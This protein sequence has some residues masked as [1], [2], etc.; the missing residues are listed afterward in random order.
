VQQA[1]GAV[2]ALREKQ[3]DHAFTPKRRSREADA[4]LARHSTEARRTLESLMQQVRRG[5]PQRS[6]DAS[7]R[8][9]CRVLQE[10]HN[11]QPVP[12]AGVCLRVS[13]QARSMLVVLAARLLGFP[14]LQCHCNLYKQMCCRRLPSTV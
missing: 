12:A 9:S 11:R 6:P 1:Q 3:A 8:P 5:E 2:A 14:F 4:A 13:A 7:T 10:P